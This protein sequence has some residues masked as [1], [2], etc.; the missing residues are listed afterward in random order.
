MPFGNRKFDLRI[1]SAQYCFTL[2][3]YHPSGNLK[4]NNLGLVQS[5]KL[6]NFMGKIH[7]IS[8]E[9]NFTPKTLKLLWVIFFIGAID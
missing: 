3:K 9:L 6:R 4:F 2:K 1:F 5:L 7:R 8:L